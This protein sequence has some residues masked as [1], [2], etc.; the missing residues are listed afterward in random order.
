MHTLTAEFKVPIKNSIVLRVKGK[1]YLTTSRI[2]KNK[3][4]GFDVSVQIKGDGGGAEKKKGEHLWTA[5]CNNI[6]IS[7]TKSIDAPAECKN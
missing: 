6:I 4:N 3:Y 1:T 5:V 7:L 2:Y